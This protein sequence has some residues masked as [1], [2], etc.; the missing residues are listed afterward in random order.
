MHSVG[1]RTS[2]SARQHLCR[3]SW[4]IVSFVCQFMLFS[5]WFV[6]LFKLF[7]CIYLAFQSFLFAIIDFYFNFT[8]SM[9]VQ[10]KRTIVSIAQNTATVMRMICACICLVVI[11]TIFILN[12]HQHIRMNVL[13]LPV[14]AIYRGLDPFIERLSMCIHK[15]WLHWSRITHSKRSVICTVK[16]AISQ[17]LLCQNNFFSYCFSTSGKR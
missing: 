9:F 16:L 2:R 17:R 7:M 8:G 14:Y 12:D 11:C 13:G 1:L 5:C 4:K 6:Y 15:L 3:F 10:N